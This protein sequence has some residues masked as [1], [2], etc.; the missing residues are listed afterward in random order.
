MKV[1]PLSPFFLLQIVI[2]KWGLHVAKTSAYFHF[3]PVSVILDA[4]GRY[5]HLR[6]LKQAFM[7]QCRLLGSMCVVYPDG[8]R[9]TFIYLLRL[10]LS[11]IRYHSLGKLD[12]VYGEDGS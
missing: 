1:S 3:N 11:T 7:I 4:K 5:I 9:A 6:L 2:W 12:W 8:N 10:D